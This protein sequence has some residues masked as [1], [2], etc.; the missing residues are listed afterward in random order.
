MIK[1]ISKTF[2]G[3]LISGLGFYLAYFY[4]TE[5]DKGLTPL[6]LIP[7]GFLIILG[8]Y[9]LIRAGKSDVTI[10]KK[11]DLN[12][13]STVKKG[14]ADTLIKNN[15]LSSKWAKTVEKRDRLKLLEISAASEEAND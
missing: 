5:M 13:S 6:I 15:E 14:L 11:P 8:V 7:S 2:L 12:E 4:L 10:V 1:V 3:L 9:L